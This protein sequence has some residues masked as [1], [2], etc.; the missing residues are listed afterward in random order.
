MKK[1]PFNERKYQYTGSGMQLVEIEKNEYDG[2]EG[3]TTFSQD[4]YFVADWSV[5]VQGKEMA[6]TNTLN[7]PHTEYFIPDWGNIEGFVFH[8]E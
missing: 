3:N 7:I 5:Y 8:N 1:E 2:D 4:N 6:S